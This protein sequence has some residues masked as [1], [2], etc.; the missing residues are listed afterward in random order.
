MLPMQLLEK[1]KFGFGCRDLCDSFTA[2]VHNQCVIG[3]GGSLFDFF[4]RGIFL[5]CKRRTKLLRVL[6]KDFSDFHLQKYF[7]TNYT[8]WSFDLTVHCCIACSDT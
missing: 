4:I 8:R 5:L 3:G 1:Y 6:S 7:P 2:W